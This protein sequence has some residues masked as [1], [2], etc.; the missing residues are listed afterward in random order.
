[1][2]GR[3]ETTKKDEVS[4]R[5]KLP[6][7]IDAPYRENKQRFTQYAEEGMQKVEMRA[8]ALLTVT[9]VMGARATIV[10]K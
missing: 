5:N 10:F 3:L 4:F 6:W 8:A 7:T 2:N 9:D 1:M